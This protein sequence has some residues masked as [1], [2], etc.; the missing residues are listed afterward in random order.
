MAQSGGTML[1]GCSRVLIVIDRFHAPRS[2]LYTSI[3]NTR[4]AIAPSFPTAGLGMQSP[5]ARVACAMRRTDIDKAC[6]HATLARRHCMLTPA[7]EH[8]KYQILTGL[9]INMSAPPGNA[10]CNALRYVTQSVAG[11]VTTQQSVGTICALNTNLNTLRRR[12]Q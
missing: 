11:W 7:G 2:S 5:P 3:D 9:C 8:E 4:R 6:R 12:K 10:L 1:I